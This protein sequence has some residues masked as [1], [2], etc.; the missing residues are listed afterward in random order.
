[1]LRNK[2]KIEVLLF[3]DPG[4]ILE[5]RSQILFRDQ[6]FVILNAQMLSCPGGNLCA[7]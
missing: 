4:S 3:R 5:A 7:I 2:A 6:L 1:M